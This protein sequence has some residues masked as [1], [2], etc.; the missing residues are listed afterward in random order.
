MKVLRQSLKSDGS[1]THANI[2]LRFDQF[3]LDP[4][5]F[6]DKDTKGTNEIPVNPTTGQNV[7]KSM[8]QNFE[9][10]HHG[11]WCR[12]A[13]KDENKATD[14]R[15][16]DV[17]LDAIQRNIKMLEIG[18][19]DSESDNSNSDDESFDGKSIS[20]YSFQ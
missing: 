11:V 9:D 18:D 17:E 13:V 19:A 2:A 14:E 5:I 1:I 15:E 8:L 20:F 4:N 10:N 6:A 3:A 12:I 7:V 16:L